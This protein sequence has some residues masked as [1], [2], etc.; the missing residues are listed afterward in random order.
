MHVYILAKVLL[1]L[2]YLLCYIFC[3]EGKFYYGVRIVT[4]SQKGSSATTWD[5]F[6]TLTGT[7]A[8]SERISLGLFQTLFA[9]DSFNKSTYDDMI[10][11][12]DQNLGDVRIVGVGLRNDMIT[13]WVDFFVDRH[14]YVEYVSIIDFQNKEAE[15]QFPCY[16]WL[17]YDGK[18]VTAVSTVGMYTVHV[19]TN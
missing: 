19:V 6:F 5:V 1:H 10:I 8:Q 12:T 9:M 16:H 14:W 15:T 4:G 11:E 3:V 18:E 13:K 17:E 2:M 7:K